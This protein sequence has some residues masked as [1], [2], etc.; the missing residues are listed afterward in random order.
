VSRWF[1]ALT[2][3]VLLCACAAEVTRHPA[4][5]T[6]RNDGTSYVVLQPAALLLDSGYTRTIPSGM[7]FVNAGQVREGMVLRPQDSVFTIEGRNQH[8]A[9][10]VVDNGRV[11][12]FYLPVEKAFSP[13]SRPVALTLERNP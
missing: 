13:L 10:P 3:S 8:E 5:I 4:D 7:K 6:L 12:G 9:Y 11:V 2:V 1:A